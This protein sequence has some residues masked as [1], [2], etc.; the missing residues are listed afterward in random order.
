M[1]AKVV[2]VKNSAGVVNADS[3][4]AVVNRVAGAS[5]QDGDEVHKLYAF[6]DGKE[7]VNTLKN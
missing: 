4:I 2:I 1:T 7:I 3:S 6:Q 5:N